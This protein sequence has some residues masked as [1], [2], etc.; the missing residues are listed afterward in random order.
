MILGGV[1]GASIGWGAGAIVAKFGVGQAAMSIMNGGGAA[2][3]SFDKLKKF[4][5]SPGEGKQWHHIV[6]QCQT[7]ASRAGFSVEWVQNTNNVVAITKEVHT[8]ISAYYS[9]IDPYISGKITVR[10]WLSTQSFHDQYIFGIK[11]LEKFGIYVGK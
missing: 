4:L 3:T 1:A 6:E 7:Y 2:F 9:S 8:K 11:V 5:G 10:D